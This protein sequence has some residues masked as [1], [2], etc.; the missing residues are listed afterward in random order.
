[1]KIAKPLIAA[2]LSGLMLTACAS[3]PTVYRAQAGAPNDVGYSEYRLEAGRYRV[4][5]QG[6]PG[7]PQAKVAD[8]ALLRAAELALRDGY[9]WFRIADRSTSASGYDRG[10]RMSV[11]GG[12]ASFG[13]RT[14]FG[15][16]LGTSFDLGPG[17]SVAQ[18]IEVVFGKGPTPRDRDAYDARE[19]V[20]TVGYGRGRV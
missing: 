8:Y 5:F 4:T 6:G 13:R 10:P 18:S 19:I 3:T 16:G 1:M 20:K 17:P 9:D 12:S 11:G 7:A 2:V 15:L 14:S